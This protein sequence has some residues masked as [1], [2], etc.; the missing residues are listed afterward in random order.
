VTDDQR[1]ADRLDGRVALICGGTGHVGGAIALTLAQMGARVAVHGYTKS[2]R[3][4]E[5]VRELGP[6]GAHVALSGDLTDSSAARRV[7]QQAEDELGAPVTVVVDAAYPAQ[8]PRRVAELDD[9]YL[10][11]HLNGLRIHVNVCRAALGG[12]HAIGWGRIVL[13]SGALAWRPFPGFAV[14]G[15]VKAGAS[16]FARTLA[17]EEGMAGITVNTVV[18]GRVEYDDGGHAFTPHEAYEALDEVTQ[19]RVALPRMAS[20]QDIA[21]TIRYLASPAAG[22]V[23]GQAIFLAAGEPI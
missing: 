23:T 16:A 17:L 20:P 2:E 6:P 19:R 9:D 5:I 12:M 4:E 14:Y 22:A 11:R 7:F 3:G 10:E 8:P 15:A 13:L 21:S 1:L 18:L